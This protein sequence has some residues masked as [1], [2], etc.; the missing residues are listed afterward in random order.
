[1]AFTFSVKAW[2]DVR[3]S[4]AKGLGV[5]EAI[6]AV[7]ASCPAS[8]GGLTPAQC[9]TAVKDI[10]KLS[11]SFDKVRKSLSGNKSSAATKTIAKLK[12]WDAELADYQVLIA[13]RRK[14]IQAALASEQYKVVFEKA[15]D[16][17]TAAYKAALKAQSELAR[18]RLPG[19]D[20]VVHWMATVESTGKKFSKTWFPNLAA[21]KSGGLKA[22]DVTLPDDLK[23]VKAAA[24]KLKEVCVALADAMRD[25]ARASLEALDDRKELERELKAL[26]AGYKDL[27]GDMR[28]LMGKFASAATNAKALAEDVKAAI[29]EKRARD[30]FKRLGQEALDL[31]DTRTGLEEAVKTLNQSLRAGN[32]DLNKRYM[33]LTK[34][35]GWNPDTHGQLAR[36]RQDAA[37]LS[38]R[39]CSVLAAEIDKQIDRVRVMYSKTSYQGYIGTL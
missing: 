33:A 35:P 4:E 6:K 30:D 25:S 31:R 7:V 10:D 17:L 9:D 11:D 1:M 3:P 12:T 16:E 13:Q 26:M 27:E 14:A 8:T 38:V 28:A 32:G 18:G 5:A 39:Q 36:K 15:R 2:R 29:A 21:F 34:L 24:G 19:R 37:D 23:Q 20:E 22:E